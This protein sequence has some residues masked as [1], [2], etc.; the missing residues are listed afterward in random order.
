[1][2]R[3]GFE[4]EVAEQVVGG[5]PLEPRAIAGLLASLA[6]KSLVQIHAGVVMRY[7]L[8][9][10]VRQ[11]AAGRLADAGEETAVH[12]RLLRWALEIAG[13]AEAPPANAAGPDWS[14]RLSADQASIRAALSW[15]LGGQGRT[16]DG[17]WPPGSP[18]GGSPPAGT[19]KQASS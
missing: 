5:E 16:P 1:M 2:L 4:L 17:T 18:G 7:S 11:F 6:D 19:A 10:S 3:G 12:A 14:I 13:S 15:A 9:E 8:L